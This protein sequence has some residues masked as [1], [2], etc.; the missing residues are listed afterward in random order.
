MHRLR[1]CLIALAL[2]FAAP[3]WAKLP[4]Q[5][6]QLLPM[7]QDEMARYWPDV[8]PPEWIPALIDQESGWDAYARLLTKYEQGC[9]LIEITRTFRADGSV[10]M[11]ALADYKR[12]DPSLAGWSWRDCYAVR[13]QLRA[14][15]LKQH[16]NDALCQRLGIVGN[17]EVKACAGALYNGGPGTFDRRIRACTAQEGCDPHR[18]FGQLE[19]QCPQSRAKRPG[20]GESLCD[21]NSHYPARVEA[22]MPKFHA[23]MNRPQTTANP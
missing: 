6:D 15:V 9:G 12:L 5:A 2:L 17:R 14:V 7:L 21:I 8:D 11:D 4:G 13:Y 23:A 19:R 20:Y 1:A 16:A 22:R 10:K 18:W 3:A